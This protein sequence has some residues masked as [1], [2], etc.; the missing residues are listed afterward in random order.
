M[1]KGKGSISHWGARVKGGTVL[2]EICGVN[3]NIF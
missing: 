1:G 2:F 3:L